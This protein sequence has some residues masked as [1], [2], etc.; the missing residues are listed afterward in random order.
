MPKWSH[1]LDVDD[2]E[3]LDQPIKFQK[4]KRGQRNKSDEERI[5]QEPLPSRNTSVKQR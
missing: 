3:E 5:R 2:D 1:Y 4:I